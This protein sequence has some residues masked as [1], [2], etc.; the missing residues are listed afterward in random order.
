MRITK[1]EWSALGGLRNPRCY[2]RQQANGRWLY[3][4]AEG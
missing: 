4:F 3:Y 1:A 2:R